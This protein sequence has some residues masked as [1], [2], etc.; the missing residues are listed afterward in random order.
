M[1]D[2]LTRKTPMETGDSLSLSSL[3]IPCYRFEAGANDFLGLCERSGTGRKRRRRGLHD[4]AGTGRMTGQNGLRPDGGASDF[5]TWR[6]KVSGQ[7]EALFG[8]SEHRSR[9]DVISLPA[10]ESRLLRRTFNR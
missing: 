10:E 3:P 5:G 2:S 1:A 7:R 9:Q 8:A 4:R 6:E